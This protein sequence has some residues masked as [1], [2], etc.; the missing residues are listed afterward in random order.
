MTLIVSFAFCGSIFSQNTYPT[1]WP[2][3]VY[4]FH[5]SSGITAAFAIN[6][7]IFTD[8]DPGWDALEVA[9]FV[10]DECRGHKNFLTN[11]NVLEYGDPYPITPGSAICFNDFGELVTFQMWDH[12]N[13]ILYTDCE[14]TFLGEPIEI[15][16]GPDYM[17]AWTDEEHDYQPIILNFISPIISAYANPTE[18]GTVTG[19]GTYEVGAV[20]TLTATANPGYDFLNWTEDGEVVSS[21]AEYAFTVAGSRTFVANFYTNHWTAENYSNNMFM[22][23][24]VKIDGVEQTSPTLELGAFCNDEC[25]G[26]EFP[27]Y[28]GG[29]WLY[30][31]TIGGNSGD[32][33]SFRLY[34]HALQ[35][36]LNLYCFN[37]IP[38]EVNGLV[39]I[40]E[41]YEVQFASILPVSVNVNPEN[42]GTITGTGEHAPGSNVTLTATAN[43]GYAFNSWTNNNGE[44]VST[45]PSY[46]FAVTAPVN[47]TA[48][49]DRVYSVSVNFNLENA[50]MVVGEGEYLLGT[51]V[52]MIASPNEGYAFNSWTLDGEIVSTE[53]TYTFTVTESVNLTV[54]FDVVFTQQLVSS[55]NWW[56]TNLEITLDDLKAALVAATP[57]NTI[58]IKSQNKNIVY[59]PRNHS[60][61]GNLTWD[62]AQMYMISVSTGCEITLKGLPINPADHPIT[63]QE[64]IKWIAVPI[65]EN[66]TVNDALA[67]FPAVN[68]DI[69]KSN[70]NNTVFVRG[71]WRGVV[72]TL[73]PGRG[74][75]F[76]SNTQEPRILIFPSST[77]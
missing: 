10:G 22:I 58:T 28:D 17:Y 31:M 41:P 1:H 60:W 62:V 32:D 39:G 5:N 9:F 13:G 77:K 20:C 21:D 15:I 3:F 2:G 47:F 35:Q 43:E 73:E 30:F 34:D 14:V 51:E 69:I 12:I 8:Q 19:A 68:G 63:I 72:T 16:T 4:N 65:S 61:N 27:V 70:M 46:T 25:R 24:V 45:D 37:V 66:M 75:M 64:G 56:S 67:G 33:I 53:P 54:N 23:G 49:F 11:D 44:I 76:I 6:G 29:Q 55:W 52:T 42:A 74:Y 48:N 59:S 40:E 18:G 71:E 57:N 36:E 38:F 26:T 7:H 50:G